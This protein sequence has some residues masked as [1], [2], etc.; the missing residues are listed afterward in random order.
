MSSNGDVIAEERARELNSPQGRL[1]QTHLALSYIRHPYRNPILG[2]PEDIAAISVADLKAFYQ[3]HYAPDRAVLV[4]VGD[5]DTEAALDRI[6]SHFADVPAGKTQLPKPSLTEPEQSG[7]R[8]FVL[9]DAEAAARGLFGWRTVPRA[10]SDAVVL[11][12]LADL[13]CCGR[14][15][16]LWN[17]LVETDKSAVWIESAHAAAQRAGQFFIQLE[18]AQGADSAHL[19]RRLSAEL[20]RLRDTGPSANELDRSR[21][22]ITAAWRWEQEDLTTLAAGLGSAATWSDWRDWQAELRATLTIDALDIKRVV[23][24]YLI[25]S[26]KTV[27]WSLPDPGGEEAM[28]S[29]A[30]VDHFSEAPLAELATSTPLGSAVAARTITSGA[31]TTRQP[32][33][34]WRYL[35][36]SH[37]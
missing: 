4:V 16:R 35:R 8:E 33:F 13:L 37:G 5:V 19:E 9:S 27:G 36:K 7:R 26:R 17:A 25:E 10:H 22:R 6:A 21:R 11:D 18:A 20:A 28:A 23:D 1:D 3:A 30:S 2:W 12:V 31:R 32:R 29:P 24:T 34:P 15:S 14:R